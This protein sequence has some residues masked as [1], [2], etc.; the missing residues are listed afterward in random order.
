MLLGEIFIFLGIWRGNVHIL[1]VIDIYDAKVL[2][3]MQCVRKCELWPNYISI[4]ICSIYL[5]NLESISYKWRDQTTNFW[6]FTRF[7]YRFGNIIVIFFKGK[8]VWIFLKR[9]FWQKFFQKTQFCLLKCCNSL[10]FE[11]TMS[12]NVLLGTYIC[13]WS[14]VLEVFLIRNLTGVF[15]IFNV[16]FVR[17]SMLFDVFL[18]FWKLSNLKKKSDQKW[19]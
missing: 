14:Y 9:N 15:F 13:S 18:V 1:I 17:K 19:Y 2:F 5:R 7:I 12:F 4:T 10:E 6:F 3:C 16:V 11:R 8:S